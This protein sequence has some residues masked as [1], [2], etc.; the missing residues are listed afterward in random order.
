[1]QRERIQ[2]FCRIERLK[3]FDVFEDVDVPGTTALA[4]RPASLRPTPVHASTSRLRSP[5]SSSLVSTGSPEK[6]R[7]F[8]CRLVTLPVRPHDFA[9]LETHLGRTV[10]RCVAHRA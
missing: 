7:V 4:E 10:A 6:R 9:S 8:T 5:A 3:L 2:Q 1:V